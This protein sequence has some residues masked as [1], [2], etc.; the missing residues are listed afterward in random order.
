MLKD[1]ESNVYVVSVSG[2]NNKMYEAAGIRPYTRYEGFPVPYEDIDAVLLCCR[3]DQLEAVKTL[4]P[5]EILPKVVDK[6]V[7]FQN[8]FGVRENLQ[9]IFGKSIAR[10]VPN[11]S[12]KRHD[13]KNISLTFAKPSPIK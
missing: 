6:I 8:G 10:C 7:S 4:I 9:K 11:L 2:K 12:F 13:G 3:T 1:T 5:K